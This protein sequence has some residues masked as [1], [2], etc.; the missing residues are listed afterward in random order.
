MLGEGLAQPGHPGRRPVGLLTA[1]QIEEADRGFGVL[2]GVLAERVPE[3]RIVGDRCRKG[4]LIAYLFQDGSGDR[5]TETRIGIA[6][7]PACQR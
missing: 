2:M 6:F 3:A 5:Q 7:R 1:N 4:L